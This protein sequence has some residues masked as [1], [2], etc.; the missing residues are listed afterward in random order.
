MR[1]LTM[2]MIFSLIA[3][4]VPA[5]PPL[6]EVDEIDDALLAIGLAD[7]IR[8]QC[9]EISGRTVKGYRIILGLRDR[10]RE[11]GYSDA[12]IDAYRKS[13]VEKSRLKAEGAA[14]VRAQGLDMTVPADWCKLGKSEIAKKSQIGVLLRVN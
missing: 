1:I 9:P 13:D 11:L 3:G 14:Y 4:S 2:A 12:Q 8:K 10:A 5:Q 7:E 6:G